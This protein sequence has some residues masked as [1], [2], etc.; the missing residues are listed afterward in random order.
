MLLVGREPQLVSIF[1]ACRRDSKAMPREPSQRHFTIQN[2][3]GHV[4]HL[5]S[6]HDKKGLERNRSFLSAGPWRA[7]INSHQ[8]EAGITPFNPEDSGGLPSPAAED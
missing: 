6:R 3:H 1:V 7:E 5:S 8:A 4:E 2:I